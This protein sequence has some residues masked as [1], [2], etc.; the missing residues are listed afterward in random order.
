MQVTVTGAG[1]ALWGETMRTGDHD[2]YERWVFEFDGDGDGDGA[3]SREAL[4]R[5]S[6]RH[7]NGYQGLR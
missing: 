6:P 3:A 1:D 2:C 5:Q 7:L 4:I